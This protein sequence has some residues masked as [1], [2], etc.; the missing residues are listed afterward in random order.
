LTF[1][2]RYALPRPEVNASIKA[3][4]L[5]FEVDCLWRDRRLIVELDGR[6]AHGTASAFEVDR[7]RDRALATA[8]WRVV[9]ITWR[10]LHEEPG[11][12]AADLRALLR[13]AGSRT[14]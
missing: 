11:A 12:L 9:R 4:G 3:R 7:A 13:E 8:G 2:E 6:Q 1:L 10:Q 5:W 14:G